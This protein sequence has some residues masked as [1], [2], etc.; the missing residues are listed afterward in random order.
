MSEQNNATIIKTIE[1]LILN[2]TLTNSVN[3]LIEELRKD[4]EPGS[5][6]HSWQSNIACTIMDNSELDHYTS[7]II[8]IR[9][10]NRLIAE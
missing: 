1:D 7:N 6:Y 8:A 3:R 4:N 2:S 9:F 10:L 5:Y